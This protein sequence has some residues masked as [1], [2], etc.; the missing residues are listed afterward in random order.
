MEN[1]IN[2]K[3]E[4][5]VILT[6]TGQDG[7][8]YEASLIACFCAG[9][10]QRDYCAV[11]SHRQDPNGQ[12]PIQLFRYKLT[13]QNGVEGMELSNIGADMEFEEVRGKFLEMM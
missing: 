1:A 2:A 8:E 3:E 5:P 4:Q 6:I 10:E 12:Y 9:R 11:L 13:S 7:A